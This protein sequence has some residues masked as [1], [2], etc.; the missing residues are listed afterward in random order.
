MNKNKAYIFAAALNKKVLSISEKNGCKYRQS[1]VR[2][3]FHPIDEQVKTSTKKKSK[4]SEKYFGNI[5]KG[6]TF[7]AAFSGSSREGCRQIKRSKKQK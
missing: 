6:F 5:K 7:A 3:S 4:K 2:K 1:I